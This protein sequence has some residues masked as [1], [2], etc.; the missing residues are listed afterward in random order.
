LTSIA[1]IRETDPSF[2]T[3]LLEE[4]KAYSVPQS[5]RNVRALL[6]DDMLFLFYLAANASVERIKR[7]ESPMTDA[8]YLLHVSKQIADSRHMEVRIERRSEYAKLK[9]QHRPFS[10]EL[11]IASYRE[12]CAERAGK[13]LVTVADLAQIIAELEARVKQ[14]VVN[15][16]QAG[17]KDLLTQASDAFELSLRRTVDEIKT[18]NTRQME[19]FRA[20]WVVDS[21]QHDDEKEP[22]SAS[23]LL[24]VVLEEDDEM[25]LHIAFSN[26]DGFFS[27]FGWQGG[28]VRVLE[29]A[30]DGRCLL[31]AL[32]FAAHGNHPEVVQADTLRRQMDDALLGNYTDKQWQQR[33]PSKYEFVGA[34]TRQAYA[35]RFLLNSTADLPNTAVC[36]WQDLHAHSCTVYIVFHT[37]AAIPPISIE[38]LPSSDTETCAV[39]LCRWFVGQTGH[40][41]LLAHRSIDSSNARWHTVFPLTHPLLQELKRRDS[42]DCKSLGRTERKRRREQENNADAAV[43][44]APSLLR[45]SSGEKTALIKSLQRPVRLDSEGE[46]PAGE[47]QL[48]K[49]MSRTTVASTATMEDEEE[50]KSPPKPTNRVWHPPRPSQPTTHRVSECHGP[51]YQE[52]LDASRGTTRGLRQ[53]R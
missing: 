49:G 15:Q 40:Y 29:V 27:T 10:D 21:N 7:G 11:V 26:S 39:V 38:V 19:Q 20:S 37:D 42:E 50:N 47:E 18:M 53:R 23:H 3:S 43:L 5:T 12:H 2:D 35:A 13:K 52:L 28:G 1:I 24:D 22:H 45:V 25:E 51:L 31:N 33:F 48:K 4:E 9:L 46:E 41:Q 17:I 30:G 6:G 14:S 34:E 32:L 36:L 8:E 16:L 44:V